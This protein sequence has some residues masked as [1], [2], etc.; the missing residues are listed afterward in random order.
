MEYFGFRVYLG[1]HEFVAELV[2]LL[3]GQQ[4]ELDH[5]VLRSVR[6]LIRGLGWGLGLGCRVLGIRVPG[7]RVPV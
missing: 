2:A 1:R 5:L 4:F 7:F 6:D 3:A